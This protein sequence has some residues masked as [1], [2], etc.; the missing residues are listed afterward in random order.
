MKVL[1]SLG[2][3]LFIVVII[4]SS[5]EKEK[6]NDYDLKLFQ[7]QN[8]W[9]PKPQACVSGGVTYHYRTVCECGGGW[10]VPSDC[11]PPQQQ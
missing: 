3:V 2:F 9:E 6:V 4:T 11:P 8:C 1:I 7:M 10:C 5:F